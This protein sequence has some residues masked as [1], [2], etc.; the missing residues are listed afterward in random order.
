M[1]YGRRFSLSVIFRLR[2]A[3]AIRLCIANEIREAIWKRPPERSTLRMNQQ[4]AEAVIATFREA[5]TEVHYGR[6]S[7]F[8]RRAWVGLY[9][10]LDASGLA[11]YFLDRLRALELEASIPNRVLR[12]LQENALDNREKT[13]R[14]FEEFVRINREFQAKGLSYV[15]LKGFTLVPD[16]C[17]DPAL[18]CQFD[19][20]F[21]VDCQDVSHCEEILDRLGYVLVSE[22]KTVKEFK[23]GGGQLPSLRD[24]YKPKPQQSVEVHLAYPFGQNGIQPEGDTFCRRQSPSWNGLEFP[25]L[26]DCDKFLGLALHLSKHLKSEWTRVSWLLEFCNFINFHS[27]DEA[28]WLDVKKH[29]THNSEIRAAVGVAT[30]ISNQSF[31]ISHLPDVL[32]WTVRELPPS[33]H[34]WIERY[35]DKVLFALF[36][37]TKLYLLLD[38]ALSGGEDSQLHTRRKRLLPL[39]RPL[40]VVIRNRAEN[41]PLRLRQLR[42]EVG[43]FWFRLWFHITQGLY[44]TIEASRWKRNI[45]SQQANGH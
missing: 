4:L 45:V 41:L 13:A 27:A 12:R 8:D 24:L 20:D 42:S 18:R 34:L 31:D 1:K 7:G 22:G 44:Y 30:L 37:G 17:S 28:L 39:H 40:K 19:L 26:T 5:K 3:W 23:A 21:L 9:S 2:V 36:P 25:I 33:V 16:A 10:W 15:N 32:T 35:R 6:L 11:L 14:M 38:R 29:A 43:Y